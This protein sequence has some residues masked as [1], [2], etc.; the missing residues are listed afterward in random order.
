M[1]EETGI[2]LDYFTWENFPFYYSDLDFVN[3]KQH[4]TKKSVSLKKLR[5]TRICL[6]NSY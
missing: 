5:V 1:Q 6:F 4:T 2:N 3:T